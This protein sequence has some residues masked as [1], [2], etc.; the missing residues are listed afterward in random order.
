MYKVW[1]KQVKIVARVALA[2]QLLKL[3]LLEL[4]LV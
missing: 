4:K 1:K 3:L 2:S